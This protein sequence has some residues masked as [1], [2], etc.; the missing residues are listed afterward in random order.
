MKD[1]IHTIILLVA[2]IITT[3]YFMI[4]K[5]NYNRYVQ[6]EFI[7]LVICFYLV[8]Y[9]FKLIIPIKIGFYIPII[10]LGGFT[11][12]G[13]IMLFSR[14]ISGDPGLVA[15]LGFLYILIM[16]SIV[17][18][19]HI[20]HERIKK[21]PNYKTGK[22]TFT[23]IVLPLV[24]ITSLFITININLFVT[25]VSTYEYKDISTLVVFILS[26]VIGII[27]FS[28]NYYL[29]KTT[30]VKSY[31]S[32]ILFFFVW[33]LIYL[34]KVIP[35]MET[36]FLSLLSERIVSWIEV[37]VIGYLLVYYTVNLWN[38]YGSLISNKKTQEI[39]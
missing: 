25:Q 32:T 17:T 27:L 24:L 13:F 29:M 6:L 30:T 3:S 1:K 20:F 23:I 33:V 12:Y 2:T 18:V 19:M 39:S 21:T 36:S 35:I 22:D 28:I 5:F 4:P 26:L 10:G 7:V 16:L 14:G 15:I 38:R 11:M 9:L 37:S 34:V 31:H 8:C